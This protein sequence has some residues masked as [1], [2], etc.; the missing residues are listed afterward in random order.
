MEEFYQNIGYFEDVV[1][2]HLK[3]DFDALVPDE[4]RQVARRMPKIDVDVLGEI[5]LRENMRRTSMQDAS[6]VYTAMCK[7]DKEKAELDQAML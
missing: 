2:A 7:L 1:V 5:F 3:T 4:M 6:K